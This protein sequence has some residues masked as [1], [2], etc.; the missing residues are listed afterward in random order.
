VLGFDPSPFHTVLDIREGHKRERDV[1]AQTTF[2][3]YLNG[4]TKATEE[5]DRRLALV[6]A[7]GQEGNSGRRPN[8]L[9]A[10]NRGGTT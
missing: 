4:I 7:N 9:V 10:E 8:I 2:D 3:K 1:D 6:P 5:V